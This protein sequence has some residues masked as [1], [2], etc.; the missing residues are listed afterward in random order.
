MKLRQS[1]H[2]LIVDVL[3]KRNAYFAMD[4]VEEADRDVTHGISR[5]ILSVSLPFLNEGLTLVRSLLH[6]VLLD[7]MVHLEGLVEVVP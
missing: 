5:F 4:L 3:L 6:A 2:E 7:P 1:I